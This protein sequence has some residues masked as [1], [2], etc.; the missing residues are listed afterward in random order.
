MGAALRTPWWT[1]HD[2][3]A[4]Q[5]DRRDIEL[6]AAHELAFALESENWF[7]REAVRDCV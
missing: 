4:A 2:R 5:V 3:H 7:S 6:D 1:P